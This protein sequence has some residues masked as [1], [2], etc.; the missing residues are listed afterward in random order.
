MTKERALD[1][2]QDGALSVRQERPAGIAAECCDIEQAEH[3]F[4]RE[5]VIIDIVPVPALD[6]LNSPKV[7]G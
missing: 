2:S 7:V 3:R 6:H 4:H 1:S 5:C